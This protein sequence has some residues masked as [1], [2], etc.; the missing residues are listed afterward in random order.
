MKR[1]LFMVGI[2]MMAQGLMALTNYAEVYPP[3]MQ[4]L[5]AVD[6][7]KGDRHGSFEGDDVAVLSDGSAWKIHPTSKEEFSKWE[8]GDTLRAAVRDDWYWFK[9]EHK[10]ALHNHTRGGFVKA[11]L[12]HHKEEPLRVISTET[13]FK[14]GRSVFIPI[15]TYHSDN[16]GN[17]HS[18]TSYV[19]RGS[20]PQDARKVLAL[21]DGSLWVIKDNLDDFC[22]GTTVYVGAQGVPGKFYD[23]ILISG[24]EREATWTLA[25][26]QK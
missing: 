26:P 25:R 10:F 3:V 7:F 15:V 1:L 9:R 6:V 18:T 12:I 4:T 22:L 5:I 11:M 24:N 20:H 21:T 13:Y 19:Q 23:F 14:S 17:R 16:K 2:V 8:F